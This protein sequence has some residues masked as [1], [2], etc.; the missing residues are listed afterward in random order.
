MWESQ[1]QNENK[2]ESTQLNIFLVKVLIKA[3][4]FSFYGSFVYFYI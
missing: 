2:E 4:G 3:M 1:D